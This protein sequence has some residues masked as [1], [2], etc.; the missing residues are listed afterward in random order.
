VKKIA[1]GVR[2]SS[3][4]NR[5]SFSACLMVMPALM[6]PRTMGLEDSQRSTS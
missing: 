4:R 5:T 6:M 1:L 3:T 2:N